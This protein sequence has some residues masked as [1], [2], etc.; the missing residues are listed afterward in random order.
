MVKWKTRWETDTNH[1]AFA[2]AMKAD[3]DHPPTWV[4]FV[5]GPNAVLPGDRATVVL[6]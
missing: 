5:G 4:T 2:A 3:P 1:P 6:P